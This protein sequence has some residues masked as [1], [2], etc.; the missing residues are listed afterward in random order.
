VELLLNNPAP[1]AVIAHYLIDATHRYLKIAKSV[2]LSPPIFVLGTMYGVRA[3]EL[4]IDPRFRNYPL[5]YKFDR[6]VIFLPEVLIEDL[7]KPAAGIMKPLL[8]GMWQAAGM[9]GCHYF[10]GEGK[11]VGPR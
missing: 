5:E 10:D 1:S 2:G 3:V 6:D 7:G 4:A 8:D 11:W 9:E